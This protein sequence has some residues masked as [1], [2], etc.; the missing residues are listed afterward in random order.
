MHM[1]LGNG[2]STKWTEVEADEAVFDK[3]LIAAE[4]AHNPNKTMKWEQWL[5]MCPAGSLPLWSCSDCVR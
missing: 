4:D 1:V 2:K 5:G 3:C